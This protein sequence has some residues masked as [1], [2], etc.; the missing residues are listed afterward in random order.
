MFWN[1]RTVCATYVTYVCLKLWGTSFPVSVS[2]QLRPIVS[3]IGRQHDIGLTLSV[4]LC[5]CWVGSSEAVEEMAAESS[6]A[7]S[8][9][10]RQNQMQHRANATVHVCW[11]RNTSVSSRDMHVALQVRC[12]MMT[13][14]SLLSI[15][16]HCIICITGMWSTSAALLC[17]CCCNH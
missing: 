12:P 2:V 9:A 10:E 14:L 16:V 8:A 4:M 6:I 3:G 1:V 15:I 17:W 13:L 7:L 11:H 5:V